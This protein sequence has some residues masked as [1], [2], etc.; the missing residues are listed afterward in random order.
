MIFQNIQILRKH[1]FS[2]ILNY[3][4]QLFKKKSP[5]HICNC[6]LPTW[7]YKHISHNWIVS[8]YTEAPKCLNLIVRYLL[9]SLSS[10]FHYHY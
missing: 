3:S 6:V 9:F 8:G 5:V 1:F 7:F 4:V 2:K 10:F